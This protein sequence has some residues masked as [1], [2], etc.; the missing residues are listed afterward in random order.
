[1]NNSFNTH[2]LTSTQKKWLEERNITDCFQLYRVT[3]D[4]LSKWESSPRGSKER[5]EAWTTYNHYCKK[6]FPKVNMKFYWDNVH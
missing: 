4:A 5:N 2:K 3:M 1:M 6:I